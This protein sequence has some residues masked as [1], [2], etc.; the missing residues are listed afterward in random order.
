VN[1]KDSITVVI[2]VYNGEKWLDDTIRSVKRQT[3]R[4]SRIIAVDDGSDDKSKDIVRSFSE[5]ELI[6]TNH[7]GGNGPGVA[8]RYGWKQVDASFVVFLDQDDLWHPTHLQTLKSVLKESPSYPVAF[9]ETTRFQAASEP[10][11][12]TISEEVHEFD[13]WEYFPRN[14]IPTPSSALIRNAALERIGGWPSDYT[15]TDLLAWLKLSAE[16]PFLRLERSTIA[17]REHGESGIRTLRQGERALQY[18]SEYISFCEEALDYKSKI[19]PDGVR[20]KNVRLKVFRLL[21]NIFVHSI[22]GNYDKA[23]SYS[24]N[25][26]EIYDQNNFNR[27]FVVE[28]MNWT[29]WM[30][31]ELEEI[32]R[33]DII[34]S[35]LEGER[36]RKNIR[37]SILYNWVNARYE[38]RDLIESFRTEPKRMGTNVTALTMILEKTITKT[39]DKLPNARVL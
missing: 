32:N 39:L 8:R 36:L 5:V 16:S 11:F 19:K 18:V 24:K 13:P 12:N 27:D 7:E 35:I 23:S 26:Y 15:I 9:S 28:M 3:V 2:P 30:L 17:K 29:L 10:E 4:P 14:R 25:I 1:T 33:Q 6:Q 20:D 21:F 37:G 38:L 34:I 22:R 31:D